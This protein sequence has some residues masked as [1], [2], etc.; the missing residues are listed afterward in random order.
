MF[1]IVWSVW[2]QKMV[3]LVLRSVDLCVGQN[4]NFLCGGKIFYQVRLNVTFMFVCLVYCH[5]VS[6]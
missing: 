5:R 2:C 6:A 3:L 1:S 4:F